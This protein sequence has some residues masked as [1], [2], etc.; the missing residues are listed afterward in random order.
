[1]QRGEGPRSGEDLGWSSSEFE[2][3]SED[4]GEENKAEAEPAKQ[5][6]SFQPKVTL[7]LFIFIIITIFFIFF[8]PWVCFYK[9]TGASSPAAPADGEVED[10][11]VPGTSPKLRGFHFFFTFFLSSFPFFFFPPFLLRFAMAGAW[12]LLF[13]A[14]APFPARAKPD[15][16]EGAAC[17][18]LLS[19]DF[20]SLFFFFGCLPGSLLC[21]LSPPLP[22]PP[23]W[24]ALGSA[25]SR[26]E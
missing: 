9:G 26:P 16:W 22:S 15:F 13:P 23:A 19:D 14:L 25:F 8:S 18:V 4:S 3:Y 6:A 12:L 2:S 20:S 11:A 17:T 7:D 10:A 1:M 5:R 21:L 24:F